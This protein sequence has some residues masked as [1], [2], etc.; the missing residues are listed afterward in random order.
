MD[1]SSCVFCFHV[2]SPQQQRVTRYTL[3]SGKEQNTNTK[4][5]NK[6]A[7]FYTTLIICFQRK[8]VN[9]KCKSGCRCKSGCHAKKILHTGFAGFITGL[10][11]QHILYIGRAG[12]TFIVLLHYNGINLTGFYIFTSPVRFFVL[13]FFIFKVHTF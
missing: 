8:K 1:T 3:H 11:I 4:P 5:S 7:L 10:K 9:N 13:K 2:P 6:A 12:C